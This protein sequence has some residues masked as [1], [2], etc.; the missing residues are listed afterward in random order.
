MIWSFTSSWWGTIAK[1]PHKEEMAWPNVCNVDSMSLQEFDI[2]DSHCP[3]LYHAAS[4]NNINHTNNGTHF[5]SDD[6][7]EKASSSWDSFP[8]SEGR[9]P[10]PLTP[11]LLGINGYDRHPPASPGLLSI[12]SVWSELGKCVNSRRS[13]FTESNESSFR[14]GSISNLSSSLSEHLHNLVRAF[15][16][17]T[18]RVKLSTAVPP[19]P[20]TSPEYDGNSDALSAISNLEEP[21]QR[22]HRIDSFIPGHKPTPIGEPEKQH[23]HVRCGCCKSRKFTCKIPR[24]F[25]AQSKIYMSWLFLVTCTVM[26]NALAIPLR[27]AFTTRYMNKNTYLYWLIADYV[28]DFIYILDILVFKQRLTYLTSGLIETDVKKTRQNYMK[29]SIFKFDVLSLMPLDLFYFVAGY[30]G[31]ASLLRLP[32]LM[33]IQTFWEFYQ[34]CDQA[35]RSAHIL[36]ILKTMT[37]MLFLIH[38]EA[39][40]YYAISAYEGFDANG[41]VYNGTGNAYIR[42][43]YLATKTATSIGNNPKPVN[44]LEFVFMTVYWLSG[45][46]VFAL[47]VGQ[48]R[49][50]VEQAQRIKTL[51]D[52]KMETALR[53]VKNL[54]LPKEMREKVRI[55]FIY[56]WQQQKI[57]DEKSLMD[58]LPTKLRTDLAIHVHF[59]TLSRVKLFQD[60]DKSL[61]YNLVLKLKPI[62]FLPGEY[63]CRKGEVGK[64]MYIVSQG[65]VEV[66]GGPEN[67]MVFATLKN[68]SVFGEISLLSVGVE[69]NR[70]TADVRVKGFTNL[71]ILSKADFESAMSEFPAAHKMLKKR[72]RKL[73]RQNAKMQKK[74]SESSLG[75]NRINVEEIIH[76]PKEHIKTPKM[77]QTVLQVM[78]PESDTT[79]KLGTYEEMHGEHHHSSDKDGH[80]SHKVSNY[81]NKENGHQ[82]K[83]STHT[84]TDNG[85][86]NIPTNKNNGHRHEVSFH[87]EKGNS[88]R[89]KVSI[90]ADKENSHRNEIS[91][92]ANKDKGHQNEV[93][94]HRE[95]EDKG[96]HKGETNLTINTHQD[97]TD[98]TPETD[99][100]KEEKTLTAEEVEEF[101]DEIL[102][103]TEGNPDKFE[104]D[105]GTKKYLKR[106]GTAHKD[107]SIDSGVH[108]T[109]VTSPSSSTKMFSNKDSKES[110]ISVSTEEQDASSQQKGNVALLAEF[111]ENTIQSD[112]VDSQKVVTSNT[113]DKVQSKTNQSMDVQEPNGTFQIFAAEQTKKELSKT[114]N[115]VSSEKKLANQNLGNHITVDQRQSPIKQTIGKTQ[116]GGNSPKKTDQHKPEK[117]FGLL[118]KPGSKRPNFI[119]LR[120]MLRKIT[121]EIQIDSDHITKPNIAGKK[122]KFEDK[123]PL[124]NVRLTNSAGKK[125]PKQNP[126][127][128]AAKKDNLID[129]KIMEILENEDKSKTIEVRPVSRQNRDN[130][131]I[132][133]ENKKY[134]PRLLKIE[135]SISSLSSEME[136]ADALLRD[137]CS[138]E[139]DDKEIIKYEKGRKIYQHVEK[140]EQ[141]DMR[142][143]Q[144]RNDTNT[145][146][147]IE[148]YTIPAKN[149]I[150]CSVEVHREKSLTPLDIHGD[151]I[152]PISLT[153]WIENAN[154][155]LRKR[156][157][158]STSSIFHETGV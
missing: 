71:F 44:T 143:E 120:P 1:Q 108:V 115:D 126:K 125:S 51:Y 74:E 142:K 114:Q 135:A 85:H 58:T 102:R 9:L 35:V 152:T 119:G 64:E 56:N 70:R 93:S 139:D 100:K 140:S 77:L 42:C 61:L 30:Y 73:L 3:L 62:L 138:D 150:T 136:R 40:G 7:G 155:T 133:N 76:P 104:E 66:V 128:N 97:D 22:T 17:R 98:V 113:H 27:A 137:L 124:K 141:N 69:G 46:F 53:Y 130:A 38:I 19:T 157:E 31:P 36:R 33:K 11:G 151:I 79:K 32:R 5:T 94:I 75:G 116:K 13:S 118:N 153:E 87:D 112:P 117:P 99:K 83:V 101:Y 158:S 28:G 57:L 90:H 55:W 91:I 105:V 122:L 78:N 81:D 59:N 149:Q 88:H 54:N 39:C 12:N 72:A 89:N 109:K 48:I 110:C 92:H 86:K 148:T 103:A 60:C 145:E 156:K 127:E 43:F 121:P 18:E 23:H 34:R 80:K 29:K 45:V 147:K 129:M 8:S 154:E 14:S 96:H 68:G 107:D 123:L 20:S 2:D 95:K 41:W 67:S 4:E 63:V 146:K 26:Y 134:E 111:F 47:L 65:I 16:S 21:Q 24:V 52:K 37:Y 82:C 25:E 106:G 144:G 10:P 6:L 131:K 84:N 50:I 15:S 49:D 132:V